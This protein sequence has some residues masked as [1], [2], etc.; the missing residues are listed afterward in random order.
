MV[1]LIKPKR[2]LFQKYAFILAVLV[3]GALI[4]SGL[5]D[6]LFSYRDTRSTVAA[7]Q[8]EKAI[9][10]AA[11]IEQFLDDIAWQIRQTANT[12]RA[13]SSAGLELR[14]MD[15]LRLLKHIPAITEL[16]YLDRTGNEQLRISRLSMA[17]VG[18]SEDLSGEKKF[19]EAR[20]RDIHYSPVYF[21]D[22]SEPYMTVAVAERGSDPG[23]VLAEVNLKFIVDVVSRIK[24]G[25]AGRAYAVDASGILVAHPDIGLVLKKTDL[26][27]LSQVQAA[28]A[29][30]R[31]PANQQAEVMISQDYAGQ[32][33]LTT[34]QPIAPLGWLVFVEQPMAEAFAPLYSSMLRSGL[35]LL[36]GLALAILTSLFLARKLV[37]PV[38]ALQAGAVRIGA[39]ALDQ[40]IDVRTGDELEVLGEEFNRM[41]VQLRETI[42]SLSETAQE[43]Q[44]KVQ[45]LQESRA[46][47]VVIQEGVRREIAAHLHGRV[48]GGLLVLKSRLQGLVGEIS[49]LPEA[50]QLLQEVV[51][52]MEQ[53]NQREISGLSRRLYPSILRRGLV[54]ALRSLS[55]QF[56]GALAIDLELAEGILQQERG[57][58]NLIP[59]PVRL[60]AYRIAEEALTNVVKHSQASRV[61]L[62]LELPTEGGLHLMVGDD[63]RGFQADDTSGGL[64]MSAIQDYAGAVGGEC[65]VFSA[66]DKGTEIIATLPFAGLGAEYPG[67]ASP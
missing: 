42:N 46:R 13:D 53:L 32:R 35:L 9:S 27:A 63:G 52:E 56:Q 54:P 65:A 57:N 39:G 59:E 10:A 50:A 33:V 36:L 51:D 16:S 41:T 49:S 47:I 6:L 18:S 64:G 28:L 3:G 1:S 60:A 14:R 31:N 23:V 12:P 38:Q 5:I 24:V 34:H 21:R 8:Q 48:Q 20:A 61:T 17:V 19:Q 15:Y 25:K 30:S 44:A 62:R 22:G 43:L 11:T 29:S 67:R 37:A 55:N 7:F 26:S 2:P 45:E 66:P 4:V 58:R 40:R